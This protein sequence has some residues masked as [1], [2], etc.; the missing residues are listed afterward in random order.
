MEELIIHN[1]LS[2]GS[3][4]FDIVLDQNK[5]EWKDASRKSASKLHAVCSY[6]AMFP[7]SLPRHF[8]NKYSK[9]GE[10]VFD[11]FSGRGTTVLEACLLDRVGIGNDLNPL[12]FVLTKAKSD[13]PQ[14]SRIVARI[15]QLRR[16]FEKISNIDI[17]EVEQEIKMIFSNY[18]LKQLV[19]LKNNL[20]WKRSNI[21]AFITS[22]IL[23]IIHGSSESYLSLSMPNTFSMS[24]N[25][26]KN[27]V[28]KHGL[29]KPN[30]NVFDLLRR[31]LDRCHERP[32][33]KGKVYSQDARKVSR[34]KDSSV[35]LLI[36]SP[37][38]TRV[39]RYGQYNWIRLW[40][41]GEKGK[42]VD[43][44][45]FFSQS[46]TKYCKFMSEVLMETRR[47]LKPG[48]K[49][50]FV[51]GDVKDKEK[52]RIEKLAEVV[53]E[54]CAKPLGFKLA[55]PIIEDM[56]SDDT[57]VSKIWGAKKGNAT[58]IDRILVLEK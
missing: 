16:E 52:E 50:I 32:S 40:F 44:D 37:P 31:K 23:G 22:M 36:T 30:R 51:I 8:I 6:M 43:K 35:H 57:K 12:A 13:V 3:T 49:A 21:D 54:R 7:P 19:F 5:L 9:E 45:L 56:I 27:F 29:I 39:I 28:A 42:E 18:T 53:W 46:L 15:E 11:I 55:E 2:E 25:Y 17:S 47:V 33:R 41:L 24:P 10:I 20:D 34:I 58:K 1:R 14:K 48:A 26:V 4:L 38:Y